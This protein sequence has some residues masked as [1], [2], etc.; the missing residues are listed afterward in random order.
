[1]NVCYYYYRVT[2]SKV[3]WRYANFVLDRCPKEGVRVFTQTRASLDPT[4]VLAALQQYPDARLLFLH[5]L[6]DTKKLQ[7]CHK[8]CKTGRKY[9]LY[10]LKENMSVSP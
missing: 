9:L 8:L 4:K 1:M 6:I 7:V 3:V 5:H 2:D 10:T